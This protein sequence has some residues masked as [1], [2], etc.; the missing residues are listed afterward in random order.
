MAQEITTNLSFQMSVLRALQ[1][2]TE[3]YIVGLM[4]GTNLC[5]I[6][7]KCVTI[8]PKDMQLARRIWGEKL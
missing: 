4:E 8:M 7:A 3:N 5:V 1:E 2:T 6:H